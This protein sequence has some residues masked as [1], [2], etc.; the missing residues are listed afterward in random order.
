LAL[1]AF[2]LLRVNDSPA[3]PRL[4]RSRLAAA[5]ALLMAGSPQLYA[6]TTTPPTQAELDAAILE[7]QRAEKTIPT[8]G[9][10]IG[11]PPKAGP[12]VIEANILDGRNEKYVSATGDVV[13]TQGNM[14]LKAERLDYD[15]ETDLAA[16][17][18]KITM[19][20]DG[21]VVTGNDLKLKVEAEVGT[22]LNPSFF[23]SK[24]PTRPTQRFEARGAPLWCLLH[25][26][27]TG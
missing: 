15:M 7:G 16:A 19:N 24:N 10:L 25:D 26:L 14:V 2:S 17:P 4:K 1:S 12:R 23:F 6:Q 8:P 22:L 27:Q 9:A 5:V 18:G 20:R 11:R 21:D 3:A 13:L